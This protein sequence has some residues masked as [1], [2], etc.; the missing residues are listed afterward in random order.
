[1]E[2][3]EI[4]LSADNQK[5]S[6]AIGGVTYVMRLLWRDNAGWIL[7]LM[8]GSETAIVSGIPLITGLNLLAQYSYLNLG[9]GL[10]VLCDDDSQEYPTKTDLGT[11]SHLYVVTE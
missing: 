4:L 2:Y 1:M 7:D 3:S 9:F 5:F 10:I 6:V 11:G 8:D